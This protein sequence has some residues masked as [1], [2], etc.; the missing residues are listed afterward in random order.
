[1]SAKN[2]LIVCA[3]F[4]GAMQGY[5][6]PFYVPAR[7][8]AVRSFTDEVNR[9]AADNTMYAHPEDFDLCLLGTWSETTGVFENAENIEVIC[10]G[11]D[12]AQREGN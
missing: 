8:L 12:V 7:G 3:V 5:A 6:R 1:M 9:A 4:D 11:K 10:R 2:V